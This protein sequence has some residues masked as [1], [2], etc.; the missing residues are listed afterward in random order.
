MVNLHARA[1]LSREWLTVNKRSACTMY[2]G[3]HRKQQQRPA[4]KTG[5][6]SSSRALAA[7]KVNKQVVAVAEWTINQEEAREDVMTPPFQ[8]REKKSLLE[9]WSVVVNLDLLS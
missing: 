6:A 3:G 4:R 9:A 5:L 1:A 7:R 8:N 2:S